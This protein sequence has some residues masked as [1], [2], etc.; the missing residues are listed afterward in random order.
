MVAVVVIH[1]ASGVHQWWLGY[2]DLG[3]ALQACAWSEDE[4]I[5]ESLR[6]PG[7]PFVVGVQWH[8]EWMSSDGGKPDDLDPAPIRDAFLAACRAARD[9]A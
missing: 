1:L 8:P 2:E 3:P 9:A 4:G 5:V 6:H 7:A